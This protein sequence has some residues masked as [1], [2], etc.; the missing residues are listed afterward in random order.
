MPSSTRRR[1]G[2]RQAVDGRD[3]AR[4]CERAALVEAGERLGRAQPGGVGL[5][6][7]AA[8]RRLTTR[9]RGRRAR[10]TGST[11]TAG[12]PGAARE[13]DH[14]RAERRPQVQ[15]LMRVEVVSVRRRR[16]RRPRR[17]AR[18]NSRSRSS[19][20]DAAGERAGQELPP[21][22]R[23]PACSST[24]VGISRRARA[25]AGPRRRRRGARR[26]RARARRRAA[27]Q[28]ARTPG[29]REHR[30]G[31]DD[32]VAMWPRR[33][34]RQTPVGEPVVVGVDDEQPRRS[35]VDARVCSG[36]GVDAPHRRAAAATSSR[37]DV[38]RSTAG[39]D[40]VE[41]PRARGK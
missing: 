40:S 39:D 41:M 22:Q 25:A 23:K 29:Q 11:R 15:V 6:V 10:A 1:A 32:A 12:M 14:E 8:A 17:A 33:M 27:A 38:A 24:S 4:R 21:R 5:R 9:P 26:R 16:A 2:R 7:E 18:S 13:R 19:R 36:S 31:R 20:V 35:P 37:E 34:A 30:R 3:E 28:C